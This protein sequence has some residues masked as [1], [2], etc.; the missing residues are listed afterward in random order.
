MATSMR[1]RRLTRREGAALRA[2][3]R[4][5]RLPVAASAIPN[6]RRTPAGPGEPGG[7]RPGRLPPEHGVRV[8][9]PVQRHRVLELAHVPGPGVARECLHD[10]LRHPLNATA[11][12]GLAPLD[13]CRHQ[14][15]DVFAP[16]PERRDE[17]EVR[18]RASGLGWRPSPS[19][20]IPPRQVD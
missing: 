11:E 4:D 3:L 17:D 9:A 5:R 18:S 16:V 7:R 12:F 14:E 10:G 1:L 15:G 19:G 8:A 6:H 2:K 13:D 20:R